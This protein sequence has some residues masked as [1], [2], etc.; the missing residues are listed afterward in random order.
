M[1]GLTISKRAPWGFFVYCAA[2][3]RSPHEPIFDLGELGSGMFENHVLIIR[4]GRPLEAARESGRAGRADRLTTLV[5]RLA[6]EGLPVVL[7]PDLGDFPSN[8]LVHDAGALLIVHDSGE[9]PPELPYP[10]DEFA[11]SGMAA[12]AA[13]TRPGRVPAGPDEFPVFDLHDWPAGGSAVFTRL[14]GHLAALL[15]TGFRF[16]YEPKIDE[17]QVADATEA[18]HGLQDLTAEVRGLAEVLS[19]DEP[20]ARAVRETLAEISGTYRVV[21]AAIESF[22]KAGQDI[23]GKG[24]RAYS[25]LARGLLVSTIRNGRG[26]CSRIEIRYRRVDGLRNGI[27]NRL[28]DPELAV[29]DE[30]FD[31]LG[32]A[33][34]DLFAEMDRVG[35]TLQR[36]SRTIERLLVTGRKQQA[37][38]HVAA[39]AEKLTPLEDSLETALAKFQDIEIALGWAEPLP[40][41][42]EPVN[43]TYKTV[44]INGKFVNSNV[45][46]A[47]SI[48]QSSIIVGHSHAPEELKKALQELHI[49]TAEMTKHLPSDEAELAAHDLQTLAKEATS[50][51]PRHAFLRRAADGLIAA[52]KATVEYGT[53]VIEL[54]AKVSALLA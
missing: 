29:L 52:A 22:M 9:L 1:K 20:A 3:H 48:E 38:Q 30:R 47:E 21:L 45:V 33:D 5:I 32:N 18:V 14:V 11:G 17:A 16:E 50:E 25:N 8:A 41:A 27:K 12:I 4:A 44:N 24:A 31:A 51:K 34:N 15:G 49:A 40:E 35:A 23:D 7:G 53:P 37:H 26:H 43:V 46:V 39:A 54:I 2:S 19:N 6:N 28:S 36:E 13:L 10:A 42:K